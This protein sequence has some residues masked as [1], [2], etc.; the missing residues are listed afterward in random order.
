MCVCVCVYV[1]VCVCSLEFG[2]RCTHYPIDVILLLLI[3]RRR[4]WQEDE[5]CGPLG[6]VDS[7]VVRD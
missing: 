6:V 7:A 3:D 1:S 5:I 4:W 2:Q